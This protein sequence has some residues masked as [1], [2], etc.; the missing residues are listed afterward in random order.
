MQNLMSEYGR[1]LSARRI[2]SSEPRRSFN[3]VD[4]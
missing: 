2:S 4:I 3:A 1:G